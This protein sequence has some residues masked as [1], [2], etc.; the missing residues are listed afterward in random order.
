ME[1]VEIRICSETTTLKYEDGSEKVF[2]NDQDGKE[3]FN[4]L[5]LKANMLV[6]KYK[7]L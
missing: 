3:Y 5:K 4:T 7:S 2:S 6:K 1:I